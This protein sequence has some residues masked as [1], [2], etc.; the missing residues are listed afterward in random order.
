MTTYEM[1]M[2][3]SGPIRAFLNRYRNGELTNLIQCSE[4]KPIQRFLSGVINAI[5]N[6]HNQSNRQISQN[7]TDRKLA[8][9]FN[10]EMSRLIGQMCSFPESYSICH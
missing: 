2:A 9:T 3:K 5:A 4:G 1:N 7:V 10:E 8:Q 6:A